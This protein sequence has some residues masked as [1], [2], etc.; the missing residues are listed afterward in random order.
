[1]FKSSDG[2]GKGHHSRSAILETALDLFRARGFDQ[3]GMRDIARAAELSLGAAYYYFPSKDAIVQAYYDSV[4]QQHEQQV[5]SAFAAGNPKLRERLGIA[6]HRKIDILQSD[7]K[8]LGA[9]F[10]YT[11]NPDHPLSCLGPGTRGTRERS[12]AVFARALD[13]ESLPDDLREI[14]PVAFWALH[15]A[16]LIFFIYDR[17]PRQ[18]RTHRLIDGVLDLTIGLLRLTKSPL[19]KPV[20]G[21]LFS[22]FRELEILPLSETALGSRT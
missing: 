12:I 19:L 6:F 8:L 17:S 7:Q 18:Q 9:I 5:E 16:V 13:G 1:M 11:G 4:Q 3:T 22:S 21:K 15:M 2:T 10:R 14:L 20:R